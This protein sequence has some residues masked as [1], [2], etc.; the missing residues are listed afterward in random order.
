MSEKKPYRSGAEVVAGQAYNWWT[1]RLSKLKDE[2]GDSPLEGSVVIHPGGMAQA[3]DTELSAARGDG[4]IAS[5]ARLRVILSE[6][7]KIGDSIR[8][9]AVRQC[10]GALINLG[11]QNPPAFGPAPAP[12]TPAEPENP[13][14]VRPPT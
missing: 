7:D 1:D 8:A 10:I 3:I 9:S 6:W 2:D 12:A 13:F 11:N 4:I 5:I 14:T